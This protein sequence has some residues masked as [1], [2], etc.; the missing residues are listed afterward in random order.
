MSST[1]ALAQP[2]EEEACL[3]DH[4]RTQELQLE[5]K[6]LAADAAAVA[7]AQPKCPAE[8]RTMCTDF[9]TR[10]RASQPTVVFEIRG[11]S[12]KVYPTGSVIVDGAPSRSL[13]GTAIAVDPGKHTIGFEA[14]GLPRGSTMILVNQ[15][16]KDK[17]VTL[18]IAD[19]G[20][21]PTFSPWA[22]VLGA[23]GLASLTAFGALG[24]ATTV[25]ADA[26][27]GDCG[28]RCTDE[29]PD[30]VDRV[31]RQA[32][33]ADVC[34]AGGLTLLAAAALTM[35]LTWSGGTTPEANASLRVGPAGAL[36]DVTF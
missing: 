27:E 10:I 4:R 23:F 19:A 17:K 22:H 24:I 8:V 16:E 29:R 2:A 9:I 36:L 18:E 28:K 35:G 11:A 31:T 33:A 20:G 5:N 34:L 14:P 21:G 1:V 6:L 12:G 3:A 25:Q 32:I 7:C 15:G 13:D 30:D 26:L